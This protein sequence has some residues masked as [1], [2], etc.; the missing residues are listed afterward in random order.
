LLTADDWLQQEDV[1]ALLQ[2]VQICRNLSWKRR[3]GVR[4]SVGLSEEEDS[5]ITD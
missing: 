3:G 1:V 5:Q 4:W 2:D